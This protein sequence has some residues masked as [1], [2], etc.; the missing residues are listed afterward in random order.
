MNIFVTSECPVE[1]AWAL[2]DKRVGKLI[3]E[4]NQ[5]LS[6][7]VKSIAPTH[8]W[9]NHVKTSCLVN[10]L[11]YSNHPCTS[12]VKKSS[13]NF[14]WLVKH[15]EAL[16]SEYT[17]RYNKIH[18]S[19]IRTEN[20]KQLYLSLLPENYPSELTP[21]ANCASNASLELS[22]KHLPTTEAYRAYLN[23]RWKTDP[24]A[25]TWKNRP[26]PDWAAI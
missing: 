18:A 5:M 12:W 24:R 21:F 7:A 11:A 9:L 10:G 2:D 19:S 4:S 17:E 3:M 22:F 20:I 23:A 16:S 1:S 14:L 6:Q 15:A 8:L 25:V 26:A 13:G